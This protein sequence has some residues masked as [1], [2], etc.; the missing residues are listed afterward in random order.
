MKTLARVL[1]IVLYLLEAI[2]VLVI[3]FS[4]LFK[5]LQLEGDELLQIA[6]FY[7]IAGV[8]FLIALTPYYKKYT[9]TDA[10][11]TQGK[12][13]LFRRVFYFVL[14]WLVLTD[15]FYSL[16]LDGKELLAL[17]FVPINISMLFLSLVRLAHKSEKR[18][19][20]QGIMI[21]SAIFLILFFVLWILK[22]TSSLQT[23]NSHK[24][25]FSES[26]V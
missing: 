22:P 12:L 14:G 4:Y 18:L 11:F 10:I 8:Y 15:L 6:G 9:S 13:L 5:E 2:S 21:R 24:F 16:N 25:H 26:E 3:L 1:S 20:L 17:I 19:V 23:H 7:L